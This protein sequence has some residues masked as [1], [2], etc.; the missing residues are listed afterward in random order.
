MQRAR[1]LQRR[2]R[3]AHR[4]QAADF[5]ERLAEKVEGLEWDTGELAVELAR[6]R[7]RSSVEPPG[8]LFKAV[9]DPE[10]EHAREGIAEALELQAELLRG[11]T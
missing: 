11:E 6:H 4:N 7:Q 3:R 9:N 8:E 1:R 5:Y 10:L 2:L